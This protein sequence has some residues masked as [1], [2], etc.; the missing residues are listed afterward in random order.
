[1]IIEA[2]LSVASLAVF[3][4]AWKAS[5]LNEQA[6]E[7]IERAYH[8]AA[9]AA[10]AFEQHKIAADQ[11]LTKLI[12]RKKA[13]LTVR[14]PEFIAVYE[15][16][17]AIDFRPGDGIIEAYTGEISA[18]EIDKL[19]DLTVTALK[20]MTE[21]ELAV[22]Y[23]FT[24]VGGMLLAD[25]KR[26]VS[27]ANVKERAADTT[28]AQ[29][30]TL[31]FSINAIGKHAERIARLLSQLSLILGQYTD[32][33]EQIISHNGLAR[34]NYSKADRLVLMNC[35]NLASA[36]KVILDAPVL[37]ENGSI[38]KASRAALRNGSQRLKGI[39]KVIGGRE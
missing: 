36:I 34:E 23:L 28:A 3:K 31:I 27:I 13:I 37:N 32:H 24:G 12:N 14:M 11:S 30:D 16:I 22:K 38:T 17:R 9:D 6:L 18:G 5:D 15:Q 20:P 2:A 7:T 8:T 33:A 10:Y 29:I 19:R 1:M 26:N 4:D 25:A 21:T 35:V 39:Q